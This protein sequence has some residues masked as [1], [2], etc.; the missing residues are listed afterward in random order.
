MK[1]WL[2]FLVMGM[3]SFSHAADIEAQLDRD[4]VPAGNGAVLTLR[5]AGRNVDR[6]QVP[7]I[8]NFII[9]PNGQ[10]QQI[11]QING[12][13]SA[14][15]TFSY[16]VGSQTPGDYEIPGFEVTVNGEKVTSQP[17]KLKVLDAGAPQPPSR[18]QTNQEPGEEDKK[19]PEDE[20]KRFGFLTVELADNERQHAFVGEIAPV[21]IRAWLPADSQAQLRSGIQPEG[22]GFT[23]HNVSN[24]PQQTREVKDGKQY[25]VVTWFGGISATKAGKYPASLSVNAKVAVRDTSAP[26]RQRRRTGSPFDDPFFDDVFDQ[27]NVPMIEKDV[28]L[29]SDDQEIEVRPLPTEGRPENFSGAVGEFNFDGV[30]IPN[31]WKTGEPQQISARISGSGNFALLDAPQLSPPDRWKT[32][33]GKEQF[34]AGDQTSFSGNKTFQFSAVPKKG[35]QQDVALSFSYFDPSAEKYKT[36]TTSPQKIEVAGN[37]VVDEEPVTAPAPKQPEKKPDM[38][39]AQYLKLSGRGSLVP[40][41]SKPL[42]SQLLGF[43][44]I[45]ALSGGIFAWLRRRRDDPKRRSREA[46]EK[47]MQETLGAARKCIAVRDAP[48]FFSAARLALQHRLGALWNQPPQA[49][50]LAE[51][52][53]RDF[54]S[55]SRGPL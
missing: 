44:A 13:V 17:L 21:R 8:E 10:S 54:R 43:S 52:H 20:S 29:K 40:L 19:E 41:V 25:L 6:P 28:T 31:S 9:K 47:A 12:A 39:A 1:V 27:M 53:A 15:T 5:I 7:E 38:I 42:F 50:T 34:Q 32:Y 37:D 33:S 4:S 30:Q 51:V 14:I 26:K 35:G 48:G 55:F 16:V 49:I 2:I 3:L 46:L 23:L 45:L 11:Q 24:Q 18:G 22:K 36:L